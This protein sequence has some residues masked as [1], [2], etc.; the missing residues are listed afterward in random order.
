MASNKQKKPPEY[1]TDN[2][3]NKN[4]CIYFYF[5]VEGR[6]NRAQCN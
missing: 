1:P 5:L 2:K 6:T 3:L 4:K